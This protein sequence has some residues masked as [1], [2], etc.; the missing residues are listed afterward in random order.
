MTQVKICGIT[1]EKDALELGR[2]L[3]KSVHDKSMK[4]HP[5]AY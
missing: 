5:E 3:R 4:E 2:K 1:N